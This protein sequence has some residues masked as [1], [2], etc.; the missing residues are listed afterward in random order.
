MIKNAALAIVAPAAAIAQSALFTAV[1][2]IARRSQPT[3]STRAPP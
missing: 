1:N 2:G 3:C